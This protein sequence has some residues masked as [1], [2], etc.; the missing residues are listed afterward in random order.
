[1]DTNPHLTIEQHRDVVAKVIGHKAN[2]SG[3]EA[4]DKIEIFLKQNNIPYKREKT[5]K[6]QIDF[7]CYPNSPKAIYADSKSLN[8]GGTADEK[9]PHTA[10]KYARHYGVDKIYIIRGK[11]D[12]RGDVYEHLEEMKETMN[13]ETIVMTM[14]EFFLMLLDIDE[15][16]GNFF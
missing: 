5:G 11:L 1:M 2:L 12:F 10:R 16:E 14:T 13:I 7:I 4:E 9:I 3:K 6:K 15:P 8:V